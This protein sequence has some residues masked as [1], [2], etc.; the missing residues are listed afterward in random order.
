MSSFPHGLWHGVL[1]FAVFAIPFGF[2]ML[3]NTFLDFTVSAAIIL[4]YHWIE[5][6]LGLPETNP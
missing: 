4:L 6:A 3:P 2:Q 5:K 1:T